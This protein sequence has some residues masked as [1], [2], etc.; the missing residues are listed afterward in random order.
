MMEGAV[1][2]IGPV[3]GSLVT[4]SG[5]VMLARFRRSGRISTTDADKLW[6]AAEKMRSELRA[7]IGDLRTRLDARDDEIVSLRIQVD[8][9]ERDHL[10]C[11]QENARLV[12]DLATIR[13]KG[14]L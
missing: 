8:R 9:L 13:E 10:A 5:A 14:S 11:M 7:E 4:A 6:D 12:R 3:I 1:A 2:W